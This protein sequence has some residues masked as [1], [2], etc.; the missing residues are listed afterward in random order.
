[1]H[2]PYSILLTL[3]L[4]SLAHALCTAETRLAG[5]KQ[6]IYAYNLVA[7]GESAAAFK[8]VPFADDCV[9]TM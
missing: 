6:L 5:A 3:T 9:I 8:P 1:M 2:I 4:P 7:P